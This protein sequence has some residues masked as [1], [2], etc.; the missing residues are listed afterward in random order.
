[1]LESDDIMQNEEFLCLICSVMQR[2]YEVLIVSQFTLCHV[3]K[4]WMLQLFMFLIIDVDVYPMMMES[5]FLVTF[6]D[7][8][9]L[10][11]YQGNKPDFHMAMNPTLAQYRYNQF[12]QVL[13]IVS[14]TK[15]SMFNH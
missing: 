9:V 11:V 2:N 8:N 6:V 14:S 3:L 13:M 12:I 4:V 1:M 10:F 7:Q 15:A 5:R